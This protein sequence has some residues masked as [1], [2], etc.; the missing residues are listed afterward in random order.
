MKNTF[1]TISAAAIQLAETAAL[2]GVLSIGAMAQQQQPKPLLPLPP[3]VVSTVP[4]NGDVNPYGVAFVPRNI[5]TRGVLQAGDVLVSNFNNADNLQGTGTTIVRI[6]ANGQSSTFFQGQQGLGL[7]AALAITRNGAV[8]VGNMP[9]KDGTSATVQPGSLL[10]INSS[11]QLRGVLADPDDVN[12]PWGMALRDQ[13]NFVQVF[14]SN[15]LTGTV[16]RFD[17]DVSQDGNFVN[18][19]QTIQLGSGYNHRL[20]PAALVLGPSGLFYDGA[21]DILYVASSADNAVYAIGGASQQR[22]GTGVGQLIYQDQVHLHGPLDIVMAPNGDLIVANSDGSNADPNQP[23]ELVEFT[24][25]GQFV[26]Q[27]SVDKNNGGAFGL[28]LAL[29]SSGDIRFAAVDDNQNSLNLW[30]APVSQ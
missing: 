27:Y 11:G 21:H 13:G 4:S 25:D 5:T 29:T 14:V 6:A 19:I 16:Q 24:T 23:S 12:G 7:T 1:Q 3:P 15:V 30:T 18:L 26:T 10:V 22:S 9:T 17:F 2:C 8:F 20:D 28:G